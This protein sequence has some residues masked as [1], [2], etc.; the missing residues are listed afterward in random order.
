MNIKLPLAE[1]VAAEALKQQR[2][3]RER[4]K[5]MAAE[6]KAA[7]KAWDAEFGP[8]PVYHF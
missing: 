4:G 1:D 8:G 6:R 2:L 5:Q 7:M 3:Y